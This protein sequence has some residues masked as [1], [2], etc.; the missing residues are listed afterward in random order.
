VN[1]A[2]H[3]WFDRS[4]DDMIRDLESKVVMHCSGGKRGCGLRPHITL[5]ECRNLDVHAFA[6]VLTEHLVEAEPIPVEFDSFGA[7][8][9]PASAIFLNPIPSDALLSLHRMLAQILTDLGNR[10]TNAHYLPNRWTPHCA[11][12][13]ELVPEDFAKV[14]VD[15]LDFRRPLTGQITHI[16]VVELPQDREAIDFPLGA[17]MESRIAQPLPR[18]DA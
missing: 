6:T 12:A 10:P 13:S 2:I 8:P 17:K 7:F 3:A 9:A 5:S 14:S 18:G 11:L 4:L 1:A 16:G 15:L